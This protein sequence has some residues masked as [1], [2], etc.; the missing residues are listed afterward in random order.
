[1]KLKGDSRLASQQGNQDVDTNLAALLN[2]IQL[3]LD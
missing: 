1:M 2:L 3:E